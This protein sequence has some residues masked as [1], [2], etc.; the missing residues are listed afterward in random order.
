MT[1]SK[2]KSEIINLLI[3][4]IE[5]KSCRFTCLFAALLLGGF[6]IKC[7]GDVIACYLGF[8]DAGKQYFKLSLLSLPIVTAL[9][10][11]R[12]YDTRQ[13]ISKAQEQIKKLKNK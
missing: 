5:S 3:R 4:F 8:T 13:Q 7:W 9:W 1:I 11:F 12:T 2:I 10:F 6:L